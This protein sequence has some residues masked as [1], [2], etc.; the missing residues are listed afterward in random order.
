MNLLL[1]LSQT[2]HKVGVP[3]GAKRRIY[4]YAVA[5]IGQVLLL[6]AANPLMP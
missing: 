6:I 1:D 5:Q 4:P 3:G 2:A